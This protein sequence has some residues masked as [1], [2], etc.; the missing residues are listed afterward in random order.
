M[1]RTAATATAIVGVSD[2][3]GWAVLMT[4]ARDGALLD[5]R[6]V[7]IVDEALPKMPHHHDAQ[8]LPLEEGVALVGRVRTSAERCSG[9]QLE[10]LAGAVEKEIVGI[11]LRACP[12]LPET[13]AERLTNYRAQNVADWVMYRQALANAATAR[14]WFVHWYDSKR[15]FADA[16][17]ALGRPSIDALLAKTGAE[18]GPPWQKDHKMAMA[19][20]IAAA[21]R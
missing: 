12:P 4:V 6:R 20:A 2:H 9:A 16:A 21:A 3:A 14:G 19:A 15:V 17:R 7:E 18:L 8:G 10:T 1:T 11:S 5:R 13:V